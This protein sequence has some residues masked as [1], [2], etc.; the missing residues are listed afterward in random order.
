MAHDVFRDAPDQYM[1]ETSQSMSRCNDQIDIV[2]F[3][4]GADIQDGRAIR[5]RR[6]KFYAPEVYRPHQ[7][8]HLA[9]G[10][11][12]SNLLQ[13]GNVVECSAFA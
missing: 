2:V 5:K 10:I 9:L 12:A 11:F 1:F 3:C 13:G 7:L 6:L 8:S 4:K